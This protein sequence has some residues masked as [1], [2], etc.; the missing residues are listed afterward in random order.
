MSRLPR[1]Y[2]AGKVAKLDWR[3]RL[4]PGL[5][6]AE[7]RYDEATGM[8][9]AVEPFVGYDGFQYAGPYFLADD[10][11]CFH[12]PHSH[13]FGALH[14]PDCSSGDVSDD[15]ARASET[16]YGNGGDWAK[17]REITR[18]S[19]MGWLDSADVVFAWIESYDAY[20]TLVELGYAAARGKPIF[21]AFDLM[22]DGPRGPDS[23]SSTWNDWWFAEHTA[24]VSDVIV[25]PEEAWST[26]LRWW[27]K[28]GWS[29]DKPQR[30]LWFVESRP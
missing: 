23:P 7:L 15:V 19:C 21:L 27:G 12:G 13:G 20:G 25:S 6:D 5:R 17:T 26:F 3:H 14:W 2:M 30:L 22:Y 28:R 4:M 10:H 29:S 18:R 16:K 8:V 11:G 1:V 9:Q 24:T